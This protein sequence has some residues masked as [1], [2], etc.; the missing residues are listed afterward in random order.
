MSS[1][2]VDTKVP[3]T[4]VNRD[5]WLSLEQSAVPKSLLQWL[6]VAFAVVFAVWH[7]ATNLLINE[8]VLWQNAI[9]FSGFAILA[10]VIFPAR[11]FGRQS[12]AFDLAYGVMVAWS[13]CWVIAS[14]SR[15]YAD[16]LAVTG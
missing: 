15:I 14:E 8:P 12:V 9:H 13:A 16:T 11:L 4:Q 2:T 5:D 7:I 3:V 6:F 10:S 1:N